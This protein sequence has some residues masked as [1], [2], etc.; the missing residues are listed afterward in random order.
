M[1]IRQ[2]EPGDFNY[3]I[4][5]WLKSYRKS[6]FAGVVSN[7]IYYSTYLHTIESLIKSG[8]EIHVIQDTDERLVGF[9]CHSVT[10]DG[11]GVI[12]YIYVNKDWRDFDI[13]DLLKDKVLGICPGFYTFRTKEIH[14][15]LAGWRFAPEIARRK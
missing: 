3:V 15:V 11:Y 7:D 14:K 8:A 9:I 1:L 4:S 12:H 6:D 2:F 5:A 10:D 13:Y